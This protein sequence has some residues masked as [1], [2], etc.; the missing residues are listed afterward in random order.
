[1]S[2]ATVSALGASLASIAATK[3]AISAA[4]NRKQAGSIATTIH[5]I[6]N[7]RRGVD[8]NPIPNGAKRLPANK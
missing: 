3:I 2:K 6:P 1:M 5:L 4:M 7:H 8:G